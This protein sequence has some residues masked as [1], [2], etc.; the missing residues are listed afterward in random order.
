[1]TL[2]VIVR[3]EVS[4]DAAVGRDADLRRLVEADARTHHAREA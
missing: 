1:M 3:A 4:G 2:A